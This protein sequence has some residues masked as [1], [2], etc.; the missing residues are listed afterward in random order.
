MENFLNKELSLSMFIACD[1]DGNILEN[2]IDEILCNYCNYDK[3]KR[4]A[5]SFSIGCE[6]SKCDSALD[7]FNEKLEDAKE[8]IVFNEFELCIGRN[9]ITN[10]KG[11]IILLHKN[12]K[13]SLNGKQIKTIN[14]LVGNNLTIRHLAIEKYKL[15]KKNL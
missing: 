15:N 14:D 13:F 10:K 5:S 3:N 8:N 2:P 11:V 12:N 7:N 1:L 4:G 9:A 6:G